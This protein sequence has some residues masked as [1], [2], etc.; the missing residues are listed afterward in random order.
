MTARA[1]GNT[2]LAR[3][4]LELSIALNPGWSPLYVPRAK[5]ALGGLR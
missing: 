1:A 3:R 2:G 5:H 4:W